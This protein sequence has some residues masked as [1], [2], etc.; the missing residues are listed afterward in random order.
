MKIGKAHSWTFAVTMSGLVIQGS[1]LAISFGEYEQISMFC[2]APSSGQYAWLGYV[3]FVYLAEFILG[4]AA[5]G[6]V[7]LRLIY[8]PL[9][10]LTLPALPFQ[11]YLLDRGVL[12]CDAP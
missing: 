4:L 1:L 5:L 8:L 12:H 11:V 2:T 10:G 9:L 7:R 3:H 6:N